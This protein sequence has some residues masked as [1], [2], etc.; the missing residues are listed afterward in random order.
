VHLAVFANLR[1]CAGQAAVLFISATLRKPSELRFRGSTAVS[2]I[3]STL[4]LKLSCD[5]FVPESRH[6][7]Q[8]LRDGL[9]TRVECCGFIL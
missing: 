6:G 8:A 3:H 4:S 2:A 5:I 7:L 9:L 1:T